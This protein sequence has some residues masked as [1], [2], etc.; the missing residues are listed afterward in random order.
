V[1]RSEGEKLPGCLAT[2]SKSYKI[3]SWKEFLKAFVILTHNFQHCISLSVDSSKNWRMPLI[4]T[5]SRYSL[6]KGERIVCFEL[7]RGLRELND[8]SLHFILLAILFHT[9]T[10]RCG[11]NSCVASVSTYSLFWKFSP[12][13]HY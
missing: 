13:T 1:E 4:V 6:I 8:G 2:I 5:S 10:G 9:C 3:E 7:I 11:L 12:S